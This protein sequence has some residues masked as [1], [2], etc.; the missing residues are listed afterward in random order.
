MLVTETGLKSLKE[1]LG[2]V[3]DSTA[4]CSSTLNV[5]YLCAIEIVCYQ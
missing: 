2:I 1:I 4:K 5:M 3:R